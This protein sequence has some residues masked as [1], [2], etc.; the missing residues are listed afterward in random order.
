MGIFFSLLTDVMCDGT[1]VCRGSQSIFILA[2]N[3][4][5]GIYVTQC[6]MC[7]S[8]PRNIRTCMRSVD[9]IYTS[10]KRKLQRHNIG[11]SIYIHRLDW[12]IYY[13]QKRPRLL[14]IH[15]HKHS[16]SYLFVFLTFLF[17]WP[18]SF[19]RTLRS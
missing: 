1:G 16:N 2:D 13:I 4:K 7:D 18:S 15:S 5:P 10:R 19:E 9:F 3:N 8:Q 12:T 6:N 14:F 11:Q 17:T